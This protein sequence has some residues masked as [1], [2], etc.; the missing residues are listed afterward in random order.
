MIALVLGFG[1]QRGEIGAGVGFRIALA[2]ADFSPGDLREIFSLLRL[3]AVFEQRRTEHPDAE[4]RQRGTAME[5]RPLLAQHLGFLALE[6]AAAILLRP[7]R[8]GPAA[9]AHAL[10]PNPLVVR[11]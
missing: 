4:A 3:G 2:P 8:Y 1:L 9:R 10:Q 7:F 11:L 5:P 6:P